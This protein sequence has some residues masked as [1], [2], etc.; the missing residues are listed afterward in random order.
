MESLDIFGMHYSA[1]YNMQTNKTD[2]IKL[3]FSLSPSCSS[4]AV[5]ALLVVSVS[6][7]ALNLNNR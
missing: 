5:V 6:T 1:D 4:H 7:I 3:K 2:N